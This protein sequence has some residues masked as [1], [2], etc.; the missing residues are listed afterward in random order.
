MIDKS[1]DA[2]LRGQIQ[3]LVEHISRRKTV[4]L[5]L[6]SYTKRV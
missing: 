6:S 4:H 1:Y 3:A 5:T 2:M